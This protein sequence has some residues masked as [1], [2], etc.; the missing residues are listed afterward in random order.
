MIISTYDPDSLHESFGID[1]SSIDMERVESM[2]VGAA[3]GRLAPGAKSDAHQHDETETFVIVAGAGD[4]VVNSGRTPVA[5]GQVIQF[6]PFETHHLENTGETDLVFATWYWRDAAR[7]EKTA[8]RTGRRRFDDRPVFV[9]SSPTTPNGDL[10]LGHLSGPYLGADVYTRFQRMNGVRAWHVAGS[11]DFQSYVEGTA[12]REGRTPAETA[13]HY[14]AEILATHELMDIGVDQ[15]TVSNRDPGYVEGV[16]AFYARIAASDLVAP[17]E[18]EALFDP[19]SGRYLYEVDVA[20]GCPTCGNPTGGNMCEECGEPNFCADL[21]EPFATASDARPRTGT[22]VRQTLALD[23]MRHEIEL[24]HRLGRVPARVKELTDRLFSRERL[25][26]AITHPGEWGTAP[27]EG[28]PD[29]QVIWVWVDMAFRFLYGIEAIGRREGESWRADAPQADWKIVHFLGFDNTFYH[30]IFCPAMYKLA[31]PD[32]EPEID[33]HLN[34]FYLL[35]ES[36]FSTSRGHAVWGKEV[37]GPHT[38]D[39]IRCYLS[40]TRP[41][42]RRTNFELPAYKAFVQEVLVDKWQAWL[43]DLGHRVEKDYGGIAP[44]A[45]IWRP[46]HTAFLAD[47]NLRLAALAGALGQDGFSL[48]RAADTLIEIVDDAIRFG[49]RERVA[50][51]IASWKDEARTAIALELAAAKLLAVGSAPVMPRFAGRLALALGIDQP[52]EWPEGVRLVAPGTRVD[53]AG[54]VFFG[55]APPEPASA[56]LPSAHLPWLSD[57]VREALGLVDSDAVDGRT[58]LELGMT[59]MQSIALQYQIL[60][61]LGVDVRVEDLLGSRTVAEL[62]S[63]LETAPAEEVPA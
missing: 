51:G 16:R 34:E 21:V 48:N 12:R 35:D 63:F 38:V 27:L 45:G 54:A 25:E 53:L 37:L 56:A 59:S 62:A 3:W 20:G 5:P 32:W 7:A 30:S 43:Q 14:S 28:G 11:D 40:W 31:H 6:E 57:I 1:M 13:A 42:L 44:D 47:L 15:Y 36:K 9:F 39:A 61:K 46:E 55:G 50:G 49:E 60:E 41:E 18:G 33:Y 8:V 52:Q 58:L 2:G 19:E 24:H 4:L 17:A 26:M 22:I 29:G 23:R 10:H